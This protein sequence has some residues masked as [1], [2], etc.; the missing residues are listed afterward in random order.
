MS[1]RVRCGTIFYKALKKEGERM[2]IFNFFNKIYVFVFYLFICCL[3]LPI[4]RHLLDL[5]SYE[6]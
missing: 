3:S 6:Y 5:L 2:M 1:I 4:F